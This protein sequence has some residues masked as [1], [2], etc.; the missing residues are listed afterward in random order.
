MESSLFLANSSV[1]LASS[2]ESCWS[3]ISKGCE[4]AWR[5]W[6]WNIGAQLIFSDIEGPVLCSSGRRVSGDHSPQF[7][8]WN[9]TSSRKKSGINLP[10]KEIVRN[11]FT[12][13]KTRANRADWK[14][15]GNFPACFWLD[16]YNNTHCDW[17]SPWQLKTADHLVVVV[18]TAY[19]VLV[20]SHPNLPYSRT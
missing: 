15:R 14:G 11:I 5:K 8:S 1:I 12:F 18:T 10:H 7:Q 13:L 16:N 17:L 4:L 6:R 2:K 20:S 19:L 9:A 3:S